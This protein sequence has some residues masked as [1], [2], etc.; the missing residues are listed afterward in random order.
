[1]ARGITFTS[2]GCT[3]PGWRP[4]TTGELNAWERDADLPAA[5]PKSTRDRAARRHLQAAA[6]TISQLR[7]TNRP[8][9]VR[10]ARRGR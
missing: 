5:E 7:P 4:R 8:E 1:M 6:A 10:R 2:C 9:G 3:G